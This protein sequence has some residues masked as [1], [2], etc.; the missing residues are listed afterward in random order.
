MNKKRP[1]YK[2]IGCALNGFWAAL[3]KE[4]NLKIHVVAMVAAVGAGLYLG[5]TAVEWGLIIIAITSVLAAELFN[6]AMEHICDETSGGKHS[7]GVKNCKDIS[8]AA[9]LVTAVGALVMGIIIL[10]IPLVQKIF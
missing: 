9:V 8:A 1:L 10:I 4:R 5:L 7:D 2:S 3:K 6:T